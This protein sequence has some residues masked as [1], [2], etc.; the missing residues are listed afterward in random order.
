MD[1]LLY[2]GLNGYA[3]SGKDTV[4]K[5]LYSILN[6]NSKSKEEA[7]AYYVDKFVN[8]KKLYATFDNEVAPTDICMCI[9]FADQL[10][11][12][13]SAMF[14]VPLSYFYYNK[15]TAWICINKDFEYTESEPFKD[16]IL[17]AEDYYSQSDSYMHSNESYYMSLRE[18]LVYVGTYVCQYDINKKIFVNAVNNTIHNTIKRHNSSLKYVICTDVR[19]THE[20]D[21]IKS[22]NGILI[23]INRDSINQAEDIAEHDLDMLDHDNYDYIIDND[24]SYNDLFDTVWDLTQE[25]REFANDT[26]ELYTRDNSN[27]Y[28]RLVGDVNEPL[29]YRLCTGSGYKQVSHNNGS[30]T[31]IDPSGGPLLSVGSF[32]EYT[33]LKVSEIV[34]DD[35]RSEFLIYVEQES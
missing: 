22:K 33:N 19:F 11:K 16:Y 28:I 35:L 32:I 29:V 7:Y 2:I 18:I 8:N 12:I 24:G 21:Y 27:N 13:C 31:S 23:N 3:G 4:A 1:N 25:K 9:A 17:T 30:I 26:I 15:G 34:F 10:K 20:V 5:M 14:G 6:C